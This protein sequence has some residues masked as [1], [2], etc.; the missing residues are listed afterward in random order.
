[1][2]EQLK[3]QNICQLA[4]SGAGSTLGRAQK[5]L[6]ISANYS[7]HMCVFCPEN[8]GLL[9]FWMHFHN[10][11]Q[12]VSKRIEEKKQV[13]D[14]FTKTFCHLYPTA[15]FLASIGKS[16]IYCSIS[17]SSLFQ[18]FEINRR[19]FL[20]VIFLLKTSIPPRSISS[21]IKLKYVTW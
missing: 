8:I 15:K 16:K 21:P 9:S 18:Y 6:E 19:Y 13:L 1:M 5:R 4:W 12:Q 11:T 2:A 10:L 3:A 7:S 14:T 17:L 20:F